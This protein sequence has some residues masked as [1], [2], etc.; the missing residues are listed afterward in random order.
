MEIMWTMKEQGRYSVLH[1][2]GLEGRRAA[3]FG[4]LAFSSHGKIA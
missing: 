2:R 4:S 1:S 3:L